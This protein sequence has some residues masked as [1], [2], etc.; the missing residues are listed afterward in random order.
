MFVAFLGKIMSLRA[1]WFFLLVSFWSHFVISTE[2][3][4]S[5]LLLHFALDVRFLWLI[6]GDFHF[7]GNDKGAVILANAG[8]YYDLCARFRISRHIGMLD[9]SSNRTS[10]SWNI[11][12]KCG[13]TRRMEMTKVLSS[14][15]KRGST[16]TDILDSV[17]S[18]EWQRSVI[19]NLIQDPV[20][21]V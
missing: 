19:L 20:V 18:T 8:I 15:R 13:M 14:S 21:L 5:H 17:S 3:E 1:M 2:V 6:K 11:S 10:F 9:L 4:R 7:R 12:A 16:I